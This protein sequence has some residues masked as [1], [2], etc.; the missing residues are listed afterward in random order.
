MFDAYLN[1]QMSDEEKADFE[2]RLSNDSEL[3]QELALHKEVIGCLQ[4]ICGQNDNEFEEAI[5]NISDEDF[6]KIISKKKSVNAPQIEEKQQ[7]RVSTLKNFY[8]WTSA[9]AAILVLVSIGY[10]LFLN[11][12]LDNMKLA[13][14]N[15]F[16][17]DFSKVEGLP[18][19]VFRGPD[20]EAADF[21]EAIELLMNNK[22]DQGIAL[23][24]K[25]FNGASSLERK[26]E[27]GIQL[28]FAYITKAKD[29]NKAKQTIDALKRSNN[30]KV[31]EQL[32]HIDEDLNS[33]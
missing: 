28:V 20:Q 7:K 24:E 29:I 3:M 16:E 17:Y 13:Y 31:P 32:K 25:L 5:K 11:S 10:N 9:A 19:G 27:I 30:G 8:S 15:K 6:N 1:N 21:G 26:N 14:C 4:D 23:L 33:L 18:G 2:R 12:K 22:T